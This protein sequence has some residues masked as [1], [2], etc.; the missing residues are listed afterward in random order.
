VAARK[1]NAGARE[2]IENLAKLDEVVQAWE[3]KFVGDGK[4]YPPI[5][6][7]GQG[8]EAWEPVPG[9]LRSNFI[10]LANDESS[11]I[12][13][14]GPINREI[15]LNK[16]FQRFG[17]SYYSGTASLVD[18]YLL[19]QHHGLPTRLLDWTTNPLAALFFAVCGQPESDGCLRIINPR[20]CIPDEENPEDRTYPRHIVNVR[21]RIV[22]ET[23]DFLFGEGPEP[24]DPFVVPVVP[25]Q[26]DGRIFQQSSCFT[27][28]MPGSGD[29]PKESL[30]KL[31]IPKDAKQALLRQL[32]RL[33]INWGTIYA[34]LDHVAKDIKTAWGLEP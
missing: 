4:G 9:A 22:V 29:L 2:V 5:W 12:S 1:S 19:A 15:T 3:N 17:A 7:R 25:D 32:G 26:V 8:D 20:F 16:Q 13:G 31:I 18:V 28:H 33:N 21:H 10:K 23:V 27:L 30:D 24:K 6:Y 34:D 14:L 11:I